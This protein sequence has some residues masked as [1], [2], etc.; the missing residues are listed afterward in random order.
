MVKNGTFASPATARAISVLPVPGRADEQHAARN[1]SAEALEFTGV[2][3]EFDDLLQI[4]FR[5]VDTGN[6]FK[7][8]A[9]MRLREQFRPRFAEAECLAA[10][11]LHLT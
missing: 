8:D 11:A 5:L 10:R 3:Q 4:L 9:T 6:V 2:A 1:A 7:R